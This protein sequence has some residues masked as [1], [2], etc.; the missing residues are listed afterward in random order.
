MKNKFESINGL[1]SQGDFLLAIGII[2]VLAGLIIPVPPFIIDVFLAFNLGIAMVI[3]MVS[4]FVKK[5]LDFS[6]FPSILLFTALLRIAMNVA[7][8]RQILLAGYGG[9]IINAFGHFVVGGNYIVGVVIFI[10]ILVIQVTVIT[11]GST[12]IS[13]VA[14]RFTLDAMPG[15]QMSID[16]D[17]NSGLITEDEA[18][19]KREELSREADFYGSMDGAAKFVR[20]DVTA[21]MIVTAVNIGGGLLIGIFQRGMELKAALAKYTLL[22]I[23]DGL[24]AQVPSLVISVAAGII[25][26]RAGSSKDSLGRELLGQTFINP[27]ATGIGSAALFFAGI[28]PSMPLI[29]F[30]FIGGLLG[31]VTLYVK[32]AKTKQESDEQKILEEEKSKKPSGPE[33][34]DDLLH[35]DVMALE[36]GYG[37][38]PLVD[39]SRGGDL[40]DRINGIRRQF[41]L[42]IGLIVP[43]IRIRDNMQLGANEYVIKI[44]GN[45]IT[46]GEIMPDF[47]LA[48]NPTNREEELVGIQTKEPAF[49]LPA[50]WVNENE[51]NRAE[52]LGFTV[53]D[54]T[55][56]LAT[57]LKEIIKKFGYELLTRQD[58]QT[59]VDNMKKKYPATVEDI[60]PGK[61]S[62]AQ[63]HRVLQN[64][65]RE[66]VSIRNMVT[67]FEVIGDYASLIKD[68]EIMTEYIRS[69]LRMDITRKHATDSG[70]LYI[71]TLEPRLENL[72]AESV[73]RSDMGT[74]II[75]D[76]AIRNELLEKIAAAVGAAS[77]I[78]ISAVLLVSPTIR[79]YFR[80]LLEKDLPSVPVLSYSEI[81]EN[82]KINSL[83]M[84]KLTKTGSLAESGIKE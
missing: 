34:V 66:Q 18:R 29:P 50:T 77:E 81:A 25:V 72:M 44:K 4:T 11:A 15:K 2:G 37:L 48:M 55:T 35:V 22:T 52:S 13:E 62:V 3:I 28:I 53:V 65:L 12:R 16:A 80:K 83:E 74:S 71:I 64:L 10:I 33:P 43:P 24:V 45:Q 56:V 51:K 19:N 36:I 73:H 32:N 84:I 5:P 67:I 38:I 6:V 58:V 57:H 8:T 60:I 31:I 61:I 63:T 59:I 21:G 82:V 68:M 75:I 47:F 76:P 41:A 9:E 54:S 70:E 20:G 78:G 46:K 40:L 39:T 42:D 17:L 23:G 69:A 27:V 26:T 7:T 30:W 79:L 1:L 49:G 14:A